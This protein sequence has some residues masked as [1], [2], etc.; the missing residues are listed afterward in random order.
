[1]AYGG[2]KDLPRST[3]SD[4]VLRDKAFSI[5]KNPKYSGYQ[6]GLALIVDKF[7][8]KKVSSRGVKS[9]IMPNQYPLDLAEELHNYTS[10]NLKNEDNILGCGYRGYAIK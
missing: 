2:F 9:E 3:A 4:K 1:M 6:T 10:E 8:D 7:F 5:G